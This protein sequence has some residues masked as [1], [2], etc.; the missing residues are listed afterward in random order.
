MSL[1]IDEL[2]AVADHRMAALALDKD[3]V[4]EST[5]MTAADRAAISGLPPL[6]GEQLT[7]ISHA[8]AGRHVIV[9]AVVG[10]GKTTSIQALCTLLVR[11]GRNVEYLTY[12]RL[13]KAE[14][15]AKVIGARVQNFHG[16]VYPGLLAAGLGDCTVEESILVFNDNF[17]T[18]A[19][20]LKPIDV[21]IVDEYQDLT[22]Q[23]ARLLENLKSVNPG[24][25]AIFV[26]DMAQKI[27][28]DTD[29]DAR[30][31]VEE[32]CDGAA[33]EVDYTRSFRVG[34]SLA[35]PLSRGWHKEI[36]GANETQEVHYIGLTEAYRNIA[37][38]TLSEVL[39]LGTRYGAMR[40]VLNML[41]S[42]K[43][44]KFNKSTV[45][46]SVRDSD[47]RPDVADEA[48]IF[49]TF[50]SAK[51]MERADVYVFD[52]TLEN[53]E[54]RAKYMDGDEEVLRNI[55]LVAAS[56]AKARLFFVATSKKDL[57][58]M[59]KMGL[60]GAD[61]GDDDDAGGDGV[62]GHI[63]WIP[64]DTF[65]K[66]TN[67]ES[68]ELLTSWDKPLAVSGCFDFRR[69]E[70]Q[71][72]ARE[73]ITARRVRKP[74]ATI[75]MPLSDG[76]IDL[77]AAVGIYQELV[78]FGVEG[79]LED[80][81]AMADQPPHE[82]MARQALGYLSEYTGDDDDAVPPPWRV[83]LAWCAVETGHSRYLEQVDVEPGT[84]ATAEVIDRLGT[85]FE[86]DM[87]N[88]VPVSGRGVA[89]SIPGI[90]VDVMQ[91]LTRAAEGSSRAHGADSE[92]F[93]DR[94]IGQVATFVGSIDVVDD[95]G[96]AWELKFTS[97]LGR[98]HF[99]QM[100]MYLVLSGIE[101]GMLWNTR[102]DE[103]WEVTVDDREAFM[104]AVVACVSD[105]RYRYWTS[106]DGLSD[107]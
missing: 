13:L 5:T 11:R 41:E 82:A 95:A 17:D 12:S 4:E 49:T 99:L 72:A 57:E 33:V 105:G 50:D 32:F 54:S 36:V 56:R 92:R 79:F 93:D 66:S 24:L 88:Q 2:M 40:N 26:G 84:N 61:D 47:V 19:P 97:A 91:A 77:S 29:L 16:Y 70:L 65:A 101:R 103:L 68:V 18:I 44:D 78:F 71:I 15:Q 86:V 90:D 43:P 100:A 63:G 28:K 52:F 31:F 27:R 6:S 9:D 69:E 35:S 74:G 67:D 106:T 55:F 51:G 1:T 39:C 73:H 85:R 102:T 104:R 75:D 64:V 34:A 14:A 96:V 59:E 80:L 107:E 87:D 3:D 42:S 21:L 94:A 53:W 46:A 48:I 10:A 20:T 37:S 89:S 30:A 8:L 25:Q 60:V 7:M 83:A 76:Y 23:Y 81:R 38:S 45:Y 98:S 62:A 58:E 22:R